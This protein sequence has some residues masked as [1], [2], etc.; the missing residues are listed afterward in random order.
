LLQVKHRI[1]SIFLTES[2]VKIYCQ[3]FLQMEIHYINLA[4]RQDR[5]ASVQNQLAKIKNFTIQRFE[6]ICPDFEILFELVESKILSHKDYLSVL[7]KDT[8]M[9]TYGS[10]GCFL[11]HLELLKKCVQS[12][13]IFIIL[14]DDV[15]V[16]DDFETMIKIGLQSIENNFDR[17]YLGQPLPLWKEH[18]V[19]E[20]EYFYKLSG[21]YYGTFGYII[22]PNHAK[23]LLSKI[24]NIYNH[25]DNIFLHLHTTDTNIYL[26]KNL[27]VNTACQGGRDS[28]VMLP[29]RAKRFSNLQI[30]KKLHFVAVP[31]IQMWIECC[32]KINPSFEII[33]FPNHQ[34]MI[35]SLQ[36]TGGFYVDS[37]LCCR[38]SIEKFVQGAKTVI[39]KNSKKFYGCTPETFSITQNLTEID[40]Q[41]HS[42]LTLPEWVL[43][44]VLF[45]LC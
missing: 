13:K 26:F 40:K 16:S 2:D 12:N 20:T 32:Q 19:S 18:V 21:G 27:L 6:A 29:R 34:K 35:E 44:D 23:F 7:A 45:R 9:I 11:S 42:V 39:V 36:N 15:T 3:Q 33:I 41:D 38:M 30:P 5:N 8:S 31:N 10:V 24:K 25:I 37:N 14:E 43:Q 1:G 22:H 4:V 17:I 28:D